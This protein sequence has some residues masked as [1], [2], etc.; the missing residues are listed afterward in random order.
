MNFKPSNFYIGIIDLFAILLPGAIATLAIFHFTRF[1]LAGWLRI[2]ATNSDLYI[3][4]LFLLSAYL[5]GHIISQLS[6][7]LD[8]WLYDPLKNHVYRDQKRLNL[9]K[10][11]RNKYHPVE[12]AE[13]Y[14][15]NFEWAQARLLKEL[16]AAVDEIERYTADSKFF[17]G[18][19]LIFLVLAA[20]F[21][22]QN[23]LIL[24]TGCVLIMLFAGIRYFGKRRKAT[25]TAYKYVIFLEN[26]YT[27]DGD[28]G[29]ETTP[30]PDEDQPGVPPPAEYANLIQ[31]LTMGFNVRLAY[32]EIAKKSDWTAPSLRRPETVYCLSGRGWL[33]LQDSTNHQLDRTWL[34]PNASL[35]VPAGRKLHFENPGDDPL[36]IILV[37][38]E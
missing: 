36:A 9:V 28:D 15:N 27:L 29:D 20:L 32:M 31:F 12:E 21:A 8:S 1:D 25:E 38:E 30:P 26:R 2:P 4:L 14:V 33:Q 5:L 18:L 11:I 23:N 13:A 37:A 22:Y 16:P 19:I 6:A 34:S 7:Y 17:R 24:A 10:A 3:F 35:T